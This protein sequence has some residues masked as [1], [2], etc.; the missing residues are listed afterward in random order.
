[1]DLNRR[2]K[3]TKEETEHVKKITNSGRLYYDYD[4]LIESARNFAY[5][6]CRRYNRN[7]TDIDELRSLFEKLGKN[8]SIADGFITEFGF[9]LSIGDDFDAGCGLKIIDCNEVS[10]GKNVTIGENVGIYT[11]NHAKDPKLRCDHWC[12]ELPIRIG[13]N[14]VIESNSVVLPGT[15]IEDNV[16]I[17]PGSVVLG[18]IEA[19]SICA[20][21]PAR[22]ESK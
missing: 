19:D 13:N 8:P 5:E 6:T 9:N 18:R 10:I 16:W 12:S 22:R 4:P 3:L 7:E 1:M 15:I 14:V 2:H 21:D 20:G 11:S 17:R